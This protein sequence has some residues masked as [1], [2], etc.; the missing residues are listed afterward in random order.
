MQILSLDH[1]QITIDREQESAARAFYLGVLGLAEISKPPSLA[2]RGGFWCVLGAQ[3][4]HIGIQDGIDRHL[5]KA[6]VAYRVADLAAWKEHLE[7]AGLV[8]EV[9]VPIPGIDRFEC[10]DPFGNRLEFLS[11]P[12]PHSGAALT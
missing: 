11:H 3:Q 5:S 2:G 12:I 1:V 10:R 8:P 4:L 6:H 9:S 7:K